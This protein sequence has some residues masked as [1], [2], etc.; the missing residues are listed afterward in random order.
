MKEVPK[1][2]ST[3][4]AK[5]LNDR[6]RHTHTCPG[7]AGGQAHEWECSSA[8]CESKNRRCPDDGGNIPFFD[9]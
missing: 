1:Q 2:L 3:A 7:A 9:L 4:E 8:Y 6:P 5:E